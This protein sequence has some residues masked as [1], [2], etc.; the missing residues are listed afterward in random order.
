MDARVRRTRASGAIGQGTGSQLASQEV[1]GD[2][3]VPPGSKHLGGVGRLP[4]HG[5]EPPRAR[6]HEMTLTVILA[7]ASQEAN[8][9]TSA[10]HPRVWH[11]LTFP[12]QKNC[13]TFP[14]EA[15]R[16]RSRGAQEVARASCPVFRNLPLARGRMRKSVLETF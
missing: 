15:D 14:E 6:A 9:R 7:E 12:L 1:D 10:C 11:V 5:S 4:A 3:I 8:S 2:G 16:K 13:A